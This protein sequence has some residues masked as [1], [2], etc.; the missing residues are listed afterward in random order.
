MMN[1]DV[2]LFGCTKLSEEI[3]VSLIKNE[4]KVKAIFSIPRDFNISYSKEK[5]TN[6]NYADLSI[7][8][9]QLNIPYHE[10]DSTDKNKITNYRQHIIDLSPDIILAVGWYYMIPKLIREIPTEGAWGIH[11]SLLPDYAGG[12]PLVWAIINGETKT[13][14]TLF[15]MESGVDDGDIID[16]EVLS[17]NEDDNIRT[18]I[19]KTAKASKK[20]ILNSITKNKID[21]KPQEKSKIKVF[22]QRSPDDGEIDWTWNINRIKDFVRA[23]TKPYPGAWTIIN[24][25]KVIL[26]D[27]SIEE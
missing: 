2:I 16:Q 12:A 13:G 6:T 19:E 7:Y 18:M 9:K 5:V 27:I 3:L 11:A 17:I 8:A 14:V 10:V 21:Y 15:R 23:Q 4:V 22:P 25:K 20:I 24:N 26:W 1:R